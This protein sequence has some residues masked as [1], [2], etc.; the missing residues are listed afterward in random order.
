MLSYNKIE[1]FINPLSIIRNFLAFLLGYVIFFVV[2]GTLDPAS[3]LAPLG[4]V[5]A[6]NSIYYI[7]DIKDLE[8]DKKDSHKWK[9]KPLLNGSLTKK[10]ATYLYFFYLITGLILSFFA[11]TFFGFTVLFLLILNL[12]HTFFFKKTRLLLLINMALIQMTK[13]TL[14]WIAVSSSF[15]VFPFYFIVFCGLLY[16]TSYLF[17]KK[18]KEVVEVN[19]NKK[20]FRKMFNKPINS[21]FSI[22]TLASLAVSF[23]TYNFRLHLLAM[24]LIVIIFTFSLK[25]VKARRLDLYRTYHI[26]LTLVYVGVILS[27]FL[28][29]YIPELV[30]L[31]RLLLV[32]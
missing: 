29:S 31:N 21:F 11:G 14:G 24:I 12:L 2:N 15:E 7:N 30:A 28:I 26:L 13:I 17:Y 3:L 8:E 32:V 18:E 10:K 27:F 16:A 1:A 9:N 19:R 4:F 6:Y 23:L 22:I 5:I 20:I 25:L